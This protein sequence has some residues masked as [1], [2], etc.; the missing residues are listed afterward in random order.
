MG[1]FGCQIPHGKMKV[2]MCRQPPLAVPAFPRHRCAQPVFERR[3][4][5]IEAVCRLGPL[6]NANQEFA[7][8]ALLCHAKAFDLFYCCRRKMKKPAK[9]I[10][11]PFLS[12][13]ESE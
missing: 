9:Y 13:N 4:L 5:N 12:P 1:E 8:P 10:E 6:A 7:L 11:V 2:C 3:R